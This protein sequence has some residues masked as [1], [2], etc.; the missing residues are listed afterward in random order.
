M[1]MKQFYITYKPAGQHDDSEVVE[2][3]FINLQGNMM[4]LKQIFK[5]MDPDLM[6]NSSHGS[7]GELQLSFKH[8]ASREVLL[9]KVIRARE[10][11]ARNLRGKAANAYVMVC[12]GILIP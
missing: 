2:I 6:N 12:F 8:D 9:V 1:I 10:L 3:L 5:K 7:Q 4:I 11:N